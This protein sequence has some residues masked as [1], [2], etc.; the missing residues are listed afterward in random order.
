[1]FPFSLRWV[2]TLSLFFFLFG[3]WVLSFTSLDE[4]RNMDAVQN[5]LNSKDFVSPIY[6]CEWRFEKPPMLYWLISLSSYLFG[7]NEFSARLISGL[8]AVGLTLLT[9]FIARDFF[10]KDIAIKSALLLMTFPHLWLESRAVVPE[11]L[12]TFFALLGL[13]AFLKERFTL[14][15]LA[16]AFA[17][18]TKGPVGV[19]LS[20][21]AYLLWKRRLD[22]IKPTGLLLFILVGF[23][24]YALMLFQHGYEYF[25]RFFIYENLMRYTGQRST[26]PA[27]FYYYLLVLLVA[28][29]WYVPLYPKL[30]RHFKR[31]WLPLLLWA[32][33]VILFFSLAK[34][35]LHH[36]ILFSYPPI[37]IM[38][39]Y[40]V[41]ERYL[42]VVLGLSTVSI[43]LLTLGLHL[44]EKERFTPKAYP[45]VKTYKGDVY[46]YRAEDSALVFYSGRC[47]KKLE[48][49]H[50]TEGLVI[51]KDKYSKDFERCKPLVK[52]REFDGF[53]M[54][55]DCQ[56]GLK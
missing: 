48:E 35:K 46:F 34:N 20:V 24:W 37:A 19:V 30:I 15:W 52:G 31:E 14:G 9:Y 33:F 41:S 56:N 2:L 42:K 16:L 13:Y 36:Y 55:L 4:G 40:L 21:G 50:R 3:S 51:T 39:S 47:I 6:N 18:L 26:H 53:Y 22:F 5:M 27:P 11:M 29:L 1:M 17:F 43:L 32:F 12:N 8:S 28:T 49:S 10:S 7:L 25:Y 23:S 54:L 44:Y 38:L 45:V